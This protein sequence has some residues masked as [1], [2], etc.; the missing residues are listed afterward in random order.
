[1]L[2]DILPT[3]ERMNRM[4][5]PGVL[6]AVCTLCDGNAEDTSEHALLTCSYIRVG[7][8]N[9]LLALQHEDPTMTLERVKFLDFRYDDLYPMI[10]LTASILKQLW[11]SRVEKKRCTWPSVRAQ[12]K[13][14]VLLLRKGRLAKFADKVHLMLDAT[15]PIAV[16]T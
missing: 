12:V 3:R 10:F 13:S 9:L 2:H 16:D 1:M 6:S 14:Q 5:L 7:S 11:T 8:E 15:P 4:N